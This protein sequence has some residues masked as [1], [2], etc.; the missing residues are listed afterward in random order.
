MSLRSLL[1]HGNSC[2]VLGMQK[3]IE[4]KKET[5]PVSGRSPVRGTF[6]LTCYD[7]SSSSAYTSVGLSS[8]S[9]MRVSS[10]SSL[11]THGIPFPPCTLSAHASGFLPPS[12][13]LQSLF[14]LSPW[15]LPCCSLYL[16]PGVLALC[17][18]H[19][20]G[21]GLTHVSAGHTCHR[22]PGCPVLGQAPKRPSCLF[23]L[24][25]CTSLGLMT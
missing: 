15:L 13:V 16:L 3:K 12:P 9:P 23:L 22:G 20:W 14:A 2:F 6:L 19:L 25:P 5:K 8:F 11:L 1:K 24:A 21:G 18:K 7:V 4:Q 17:L 10:V